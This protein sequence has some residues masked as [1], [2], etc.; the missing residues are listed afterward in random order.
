MTTQMQK[1]AH[2]E[3]GSITALTYKDEPV[4]TLDEIA[5]LSGHA[6]SDGVNRVLQKHGTEGVHF[7]TIKGAELVA[8]YFAYPSL[9]GANMVRSATLITERGFYKVLLHSETERA[10]KVQDWITDEVMPALHRTGTYSVPNHKLALPPA[11]EAALARVVAYV[12]AQIAKENPLRPAPAGLCCDRE[13]MVH[14]GMPDT[15]AINRAARAIRKTFLK[16]GRTF[17]A[18]YLNAFGNGQPMYY[19]SLSEEQ[20][21]ASWLR[22]EGLYPDDSVFGMFGGQP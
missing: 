2:P 18:Q 6:R 1:F 12:D 21:V 16:R 9:A 7:Y 11:H 22:A 14:L 13:I 10:K 19:Y 4:F 15:K 17:G 8:Y 20:T 3:F 5:T